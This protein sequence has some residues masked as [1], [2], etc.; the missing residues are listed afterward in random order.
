MN[1]TIEPSALDY[2]R[3]SKEKSIYIYTNGVRG[4]CGGQTTVE[5]DPQVNLGQPH[6]NDIEEYNL[7]NKFGINIYIFSSLVDK[8]SKKRV[9]LNK[10]IGI[11]KRLSLEDL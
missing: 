4:C 9:V 6:I 8:L 1:L 11:I 7:F 5:L 2:I 10:Y 3:N